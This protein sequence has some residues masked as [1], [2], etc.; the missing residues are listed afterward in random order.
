MKYVATL[1]TTLL[2]LTGVSLPASAAEEP[3]SP[4]VITVNIVNSKAEIIGT[5]TI[6]GQVDAVHIH[7]EAAGLPPGTHGIHFHAV[8]KCEAPDFTSAGAHFNPTH[9]EHGFNNPKGFHSGDLLNIEV[10]KDGK[11]NTIVKSTS[12]TFTKGQPNSIIQKDGLALV[13][14]EKADDYKTDP[15]GNSGNRIAC[16]VI[17]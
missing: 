3:K 7:L 9:K 16:G 4:A 13:I 1:L 12:V 6:T 10:G 14:H 2:L 17:K 11:V 15:A 5:A 8:G